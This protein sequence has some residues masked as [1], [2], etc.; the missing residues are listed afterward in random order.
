MLVNMVQYS[1][2]TFEEEVDRV[3]KNA[4]YLLNLIGQG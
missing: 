4:F 2:L 3:V 1:F